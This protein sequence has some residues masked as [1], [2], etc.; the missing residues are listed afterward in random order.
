[1]PR[2]QNSQSGETTHD[3]TVKE[4]EGSG[5]KSERRNAGKVSYTYEIS[6]FSLSFT[7]THSRGVHVRVCVRVRQVGERRK[8][9]S[10]RYS[11]RTLCL[12]GHWEQSPLSGQFV[13]S[14]RRKSE[15]FFDCQTP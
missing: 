11:A 3:Q 13:L 2:V 1:M 12:L 15:G 14:V 10:N 8:K 5:K 4:G 9:S 7:H 6:L